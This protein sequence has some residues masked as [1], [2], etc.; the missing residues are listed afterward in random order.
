MIKVKKQSQPRLPKKAAESEGTVTR[1]GSVAP[2][3][4]MFT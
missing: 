3:R 1:M 2:Q 4:T